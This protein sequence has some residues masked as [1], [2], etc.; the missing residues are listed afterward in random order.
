[1]DLFLVAHYVIVEDY[2]V[3]DNA[4]LAYFGGDEIDDQCE[5]LGRDEVNMDRGEE[6]T[7]EELV[8]SFRRNGNIAWASSVPIAIPHPTKGHPFYLLDAGGHRAAALYRAAK[9]YP[10]NKKIKHHVIDTTCAIP[11]FNGTVSSLPENTAT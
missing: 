10:N 9:R 1:M 8:E 11:P 2:A 6:E 3:E 4:T 7:T 5:L